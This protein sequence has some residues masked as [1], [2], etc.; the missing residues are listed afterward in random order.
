[1]S[2]PSKHVAIYLRDHEAAA[3]AGLDLAKRTASGQRRRA[4]AH[5]L[6]DIVQEIREDLS[7]LRD[8]LRAVGVRPDPL[9]GTALRVG[10]RL[11]RWKP[12]GTLV[13]RSA[14]SDLFEIEA[15]LDAVRA[16]GAGWAALRAAGLDEVPRMPDLAE[17]SDRATS[18]VAR[19]ED[20]HAQVARRVLEQ[21]AA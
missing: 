1:M 9:L 14:L 8:V 10:E 16:K 12:N 19:L 21:G 20:L 15:L 2:A 4:Y 18:Q 6:N 3:R 11:G 7:S 5:V 13:R 17:L